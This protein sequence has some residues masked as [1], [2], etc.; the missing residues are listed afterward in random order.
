MFRFID[1]E[2]IWESLKTPIRQALLALYAFIINALLNALFNF[3]TTFFG[4][5]LTLEQKTTMSEKLMLYGT[6][7]VWAIMSFLDNIL[8]QIGK[9]TGSLKLTY[10]LTPYLEKINK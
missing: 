10:G 4:F 8:H 9:R 7:I 2:T 5:E 3:V 1:L 6:P